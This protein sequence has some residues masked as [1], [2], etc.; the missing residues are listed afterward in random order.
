VIAHVRERTI[1]ARDLQG[2]VARARHVAGDSTAVSVPLEFDAL[3]K[4]ALLLEAAADLRR[5]GRLGTIDSSGAGYEER[6]LDG[7]YELEVLGRVAEPDTSLLRR[8]WH[9]RHPLRRVPVREPTAAELARLRS[10]AL[11]KASAARFDA[12]IDSLVRAIAPSIDSTR[13]ARVPVVPERRP[14]MAVLACA[15]V[16]MSVVGFAWRRARPGAAGGHVIQLGLA[17]LLVLG[18]VRYLSAPGAGWDFPNYE[19]SAREMREGS[20]PYAPETLARDHWDPG[21]PFLYAPVTL[22]LFRPLAGLPEERAE[23]IW[24][25]F[26]LVVV[27]ALLALFAHVIA[28]RSPP[29]AFVATTLFAF[30]G[31]LLL[32]LRSGNVSGL[33]ALL[34]W[35]AFVAF[36]ND[37]RWLCACLIAVAAQ[38]K[39]VPILFLGLLAWP[40]E[41]RSARA[42]P[43]LAGLALFFTLLTLPGLLGAPWARGYLHNL[44]SVRPYGQTNPSALGLIDELLAHGGPDGGR[45]RVAQLLWAAYGIIL[46]WVSAGGIRRAWRQRDAMEWLVTISMLFVLLTP[47]PIVYGYA[48]IVVP[49]L[50]I[51]MRRWPRPA[52]MAAAVG[53]L[54]AQGLVQRGVVRADFMST[55]LPWGLDLELSNLPFVMAL[56]LWF[57]LIRAPEAT[58]A[59]A[60]PGR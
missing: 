24:L 2:A 14:V 51:V 50:W 41:K 23:V 45:S 39:L 31:A 1:T 18:A 32:D 44:E 38:F 8:E 33:E 28:G 53:V 48:L 17:G 5:A 15:L 20:S 19:R 7:V 16:V 13:L 6:L 56:V 35:C 40:G 42:G 3:F 46:V 47:R 57:A 10:E 30:N 11:E 54:A 55:L 52:E 12:L 25:G 49:A 21:T 27:V 36:L 9:L 43:I 60:A 59:P 29:T 22:L 37:R 4:R 34:M 26:K 58:P